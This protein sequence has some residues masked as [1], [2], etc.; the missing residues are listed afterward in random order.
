MS[1]FQSELK[2][3]YRAALW[4]LPAQHPSG[5]SGQ[6]LT[7][8]PG[9]TH[10]DITDSYLPRLIAE[11]SRQLISWWLSVQLQFSFLLHC[12]MLCWPGGPVALGAFN[13]PDPSQAPLAPA[14]KNVTHALCL[15]LVPF[16]VGHLGDFLPVQPSTV[17]SV[18][19]VLVCGMSLGL[20]P[21][22]NRGVS[23]VG[24]AFRSLSQ[25]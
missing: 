5:V 2:F 19:C 16:L 22:T 9:Q 21:T 13:S 14:S 4:M 15:P 12:V 18:L 23:R 25:G 24:L 17:T 1:A 7:S 11:S 6:C 3:L 8:D 20:C 10:S